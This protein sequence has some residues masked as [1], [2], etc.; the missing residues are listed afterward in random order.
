MNNSAAQNGATEITD[1]P[2]GRQVAQICT[3]FFI[4]FSDLS[5][6]KEIPASGKLLAT[7]PHERAR[8]NTMA[9]RAYLCYPWQNLSRKAFKTLR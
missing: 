3:D 7:K 4:Y 8:K 6:E 2:A 9:I 5:W 1:L